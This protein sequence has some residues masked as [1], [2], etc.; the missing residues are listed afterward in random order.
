MEQIYFYQMV[1]FITISVVIVLVYVF[2]TLYLKTIN[3]NLNRHM[4]DVEN[5]IDHIK[6]LIKKKK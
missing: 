5:H 3:K 4:D 6:G 2:L 1:S